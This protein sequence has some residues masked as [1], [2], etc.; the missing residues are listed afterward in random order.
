M[1]GMGPMPPVKALCDL[2][3]TVETTITQINNTK[4]QDLNVLTESGRNE[5]DIE[6]QASI[7]QMREL[8]KNSAFCNQ[9]I[10]YQCKG[11]ALFQ[12]PSGPPVVS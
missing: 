4:I 10:K 9:Y 8:I 5:V 3:K 2:G 1:D 11:T 12:S 6:Y 7:I